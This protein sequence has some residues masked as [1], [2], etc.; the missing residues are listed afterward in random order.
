M[1]ISKRIV[2]IVSIAVMVVSA[3]V[4]LMQ[5]DQLRNNAFAQTCSGSEFRS[6][7][8]YR[9]RERTYDGA[10]VRFCQ[11]S[12]I[13]TGGQCVIGNN[14]FD[15]QACATPSTSYAAV[16]TVTNNECNLAVLPH[17]GWVC[18]TGGGGGDDGNPATCDNITTCVDY[19]SAPV[20][21]QGPPYTES[22]WT[23]KLQTSLKY[24]GY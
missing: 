10:L 6:S 7:L 21:N 1:T 13:T 4:V 15:P 11:A 16:C 3:F 9:C 5:S 24:L 18:S 19:S 12:T 23:K 14:P 8:A 17:I 20:L 2:I 22:T